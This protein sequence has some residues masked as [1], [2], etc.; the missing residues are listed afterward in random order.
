M[1]TIRLTVTGI[2][3]SGAG[4]AFHDGYRVFVPGAL[5]GETVAAEVDAP[6]RGVRSAVARNVQIEAASPLRAR[7][8]CP[9]LCRDSACGGCPLGL[10]EYEG[11]IQVKEALLRDALD[12]AG[13]LYPPPAP[14][15]RPT[16]EELTGF[17]NKAV[18][19][20]AKDEDGWHFGM[21]AQGTHALVREAG[22]C[23]QMPQW[24]REAVS[25]AE[26]SLGSSALAPY[27][28]AA[29]TG[30]VR[31]ILLREGIP[32]ESERLFT[33]V[34]REMTPEAQKALRTLAADLAPIG[35]RGLC[36]GINA[37][38]GNAVLGREIQVVAGNEAVQTRI[39]GLTFTVRPDTFLQVNTPQTARLYEQALQWAA[40]GPE[41][42]FLDLYCGVGTL[43]LLGAKSAARAVGIDIVEASVERARANAAL[44]GLENVV[45]EAGAVEKT[46]PAL[47]KTG[48]KPTVA[49]VDPAFRGMDETVP[50]L[51]SE[52]PL[53]RLVYV[54]CSP[55][56]FARDALRLQKLG[57]TIEKLVPVDLFPGAR[58]VE[59]AALFTRK[60]T[61]A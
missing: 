56:S 10:L 55:Q 15:I 26:A 13:V 54:S 17:R 19:Y 22:A 50:G 51:L 49:I 36:T 42:V 53:K 41:D 29:L 61:D 30:D 14:L 31:A 23:P 6:P 44:N 52:L 28:E 43:T 60:R 46:L 3:P 25:L 59:T 8:P 1:P 21:Y 9:A 12:A 2:A 34:L 27:D 48:L 7:T 40:I 32:S 16:A 58:H 20:P 39:G 24:M 37:A 33:V 47:M 57:W 18:L 11:Q 5:P 45:F 35:L 38:P 4:I